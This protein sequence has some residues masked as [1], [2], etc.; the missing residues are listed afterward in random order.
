[1]NIKRHRVVSNASPFPGIT[2]AL[3]NRAVQSAENEGWPIPADLLEP[4]LVVAHASFAQ[5][6][7]ARVGQHVRDEY[8]FWSGRPG[9]RKHAIAL[10]RHV[11]AA[12]WNGGMQAA[13]P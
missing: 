3:E 7:S 4:L 13:R 6:V 10:A 12:P 11:V 2:Q 8:R 5:R 1:M 9:S